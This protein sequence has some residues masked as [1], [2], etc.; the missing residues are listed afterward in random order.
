LEAAQ[1]IFESFASKRTSVSDVFW[2]WNGHNLRAFQTAANQGQLI[3]CERGSTH[4]AW[5]ARR[6]KE[7][8]AKLGRKPTNTPLPDRDLR[9]IEEY[10]LADKVVVP[11]NFVRDTFLE[12]GFPANKLFVNAYGINEARW[13]SVNGNK[14]DEGPLVF[15]FT[16]S[17]IP[18]KGVHILLRA[19]K[20]AALK[21]CELW[22]CGGLHFRLEEAGDG[23]DGTIRN[24]GYTTHENLVDVYNRA[25]VYVLPSFEEGMARSGLEA[26]ASGLALIVTRETGLTDLMVEGK[27]GWIVP[28]GNEEALVEALRGAAAQRDLLTLMGKEARLKGLLQTKKAYGDRAALFLENL[29]R[30]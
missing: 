18:R 28:S 11:S 2:G 16:A 19:W 20:K 25:S 29:L 26:M 14:R 4:A 21:D 3:L 24:L 5:A 27:H 17:M 13:A 30:S 9:A 15:V 1:S 23:V 10:K 8:H 12:E 7:V 22:L 6:L